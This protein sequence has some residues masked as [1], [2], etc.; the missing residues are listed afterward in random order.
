MGSVPVWGYRPGAH[1]EATVEDGE[2]DAVEE[3]DP[4]KDVAQLRL[5]QCLCG[6]GGGG[7]GKWGAG[8]VRGAVVPSMGL[9]WRRRPQS[10]GFMEPLRGPEG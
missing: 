3:E 6:R 8:G 5:C 4:I 7:G 1:L 10:D 2:D 9:R